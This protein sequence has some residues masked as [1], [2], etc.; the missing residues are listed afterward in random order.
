[1]KKLPLNLERLRKRKKWS[2]KQLSE[3]AGVSR[4]YISEL[5]AGKYD[6][7]TKVVCLLCRALNCTPND[8]IKCEVNEIDK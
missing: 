6:P 4:S 5:E 8:L 7:T 3:R 1:V 2:Q